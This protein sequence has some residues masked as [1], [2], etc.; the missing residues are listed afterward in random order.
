VLF[1]T[2]ITYPGKHSDWPVFYL[3]A[4]PQYETLPMLRKGRSPHHFH[5]SKMVVQ[6]RCLRGKEE[7]QIFG[8]GNY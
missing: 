6:I 4:M 8:K 2:L 7:A 5:N 1:Q 3:Q